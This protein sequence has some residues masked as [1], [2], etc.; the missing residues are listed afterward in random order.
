MEDG[1]LS[2]FFRSAYNVEGATLTWK[3]Q[4]II[5]E[6]LSSLRPK[7]TLGQ[8]YTCVSRFAPLLRTTGLSRVYLELVIPARSVVKYFL[9]LTI[10][11]TVCNNSCVELTKLVLFLLSISIRR[12]CILKFFSPIY[13]V[14]VFESIMNQ[15]A[16]EQVYTYL[17]IT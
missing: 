11:S 6:A 4:D 13:G 8:Q 2:S 17:T 5:I 16:P 14:K 12:V 7:E 9:F 3:M 10:S 1:A 15:L